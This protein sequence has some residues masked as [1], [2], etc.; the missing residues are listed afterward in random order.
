[1]YILI[2]P[3]LKYAFI[4]LGAYGKVVIMVISCMLDSPIVPHHLHPFLFARVP[5]ASQYSPHIKG[6]PSLASSLVKGRRLSIYW[7]DA[8]VK[9]RLVIF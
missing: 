2:S 3:L 7:E 8:E 5:Q 6:L 9:Q 4:T 1:M